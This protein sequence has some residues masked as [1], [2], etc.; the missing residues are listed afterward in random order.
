LLNKKT[1]LKT[2]FQVLAF[3]NAKDEQTRK[4]FFEELLDCIEE[5]VTNFEIAWFPRLL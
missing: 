3:F 2:F 1:V 5:V 4:V